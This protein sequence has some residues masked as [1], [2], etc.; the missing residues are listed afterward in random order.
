MLEFVAEAWTVVPEDDLVRSCG[1]YGIRNARD[2]SEEVSL[3]GEW[4]TVRE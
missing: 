3:N 1:S 2:G 4:F